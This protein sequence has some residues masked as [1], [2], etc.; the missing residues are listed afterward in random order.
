MKLNLWILSILGL[1][2]YFGNHRLCE[3]F[4][5]IHTQEYYNLKMALHSLDFCILS[6]IVFWTSKDYLRAIFRAFMSFCFADAVDKIMYGNHKLHIVGTDDKW[7]IGMTITILIIE[8]RNVYI[9]RS[10]EYRGIN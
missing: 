1:L 8:L 3:F 6:A 7:F 2:I 4:Y 5:T 10:R 9:R